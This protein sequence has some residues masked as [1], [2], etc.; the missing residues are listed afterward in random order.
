MLT[1]QMEND[2]GTYISARHTTGDDF[3]GWIGGF[4]LLE[5][6]TLGKGNTARQ[7]ETTTRESDH[8]IGE[9]VWTGNG[10]GRDEQLGRNST[11]ARIW[12]ENRGTD[13]DGL[14]SEESRH[15]T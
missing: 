8:S 12:T 6:S 3:C 9:V 11:M 2:R 13:F 14:A 7:I 1:V 5:V 10:G 15:R 4:R